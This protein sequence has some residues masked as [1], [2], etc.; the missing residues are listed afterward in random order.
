MTMFVAWGLA[1]PLTAAPDEPAHAIKAAAVVRGELLGDR[2]D[3]E[4]PGWGYVD[5]P[6]V[7]AYTPSM[8]CFAFHPDQ[9][10]VCQRPVAGAPSVITH[11]VT[12]AMTYNPLYY[13]VVGLPSFFP[14][15][16]GSL[17][18]MRLVS[19]ALCAAALAYGF[20]QALT[21]TRRGW[22]PTGLL[23]ALTPMVIFLGSSINPAALEVAAG[24]SLWVS[25]AVLLRSDEPA[26]FRSRIVAIAIMASVFVNLRGLSPLFLVI[27]AAAVVLA[28]PLRQTGVILRRRFIWPWIGLVGLATVAAL[29]WTRYAGTLGSDG[30]V[31]HPELE[32]WDAVQVSLGSTSNYV[33]NMIGQFGWMETGLPIWVYFLVVSVVGALCALA[34]AVG[35][36]R[37][38]L[39]LVGLALACIVIPV[40]LHSTQ[41]KYLGIVWQGRYFLPAVVG[42][43]ILAAFVLDGSPDSPGRRIGRNLCALFGAAWFTYQLV[44]FFINLHRYTFGAGREWFV[45][46]IDE[47]VPPLPVPV[48][49]LI[50][51]IGL[52]GLVALCLHPWGTLREP[53]PI[54]D[55]EPAPTAS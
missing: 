32:F 29:A 3:P 14:S 15:G 46:P 4:R 40:V 21:A 33:A 43:P 48:L 18:L 19:A 37:E 30:V 23:L 47:W 35:T 16:Q 24:A 8:T 44:A 53:A 9:T 20:A 54:E 36:W 13:S 55:P 7:I 27:I 41:A 25:L 2:Y 42:I 45:T 10:A 39:V 5:V 1:N 17:Y 31:H 28:S 22:L 38:R 6:A 11:V 50:L 26:R 34:L 12:T 52:A 49:G 51:A